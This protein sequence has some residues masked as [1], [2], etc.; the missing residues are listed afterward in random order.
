MQQLDGLMSRW[1]YPA[2]CICWSASTIW[3]QM[4]TVVCSVRHLLGESTHVGQVLAKQLHD[5]EGAVGIDE[6]DQPGDLGGRLQAAQ[7]LLLVQ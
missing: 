3:T 7:H 5:Q 4:S 2:S 6:L 1:M